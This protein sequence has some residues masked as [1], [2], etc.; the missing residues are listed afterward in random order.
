MTGMK[1]L[2]WSVAEEVCDHSPIGV[3]SGGWGS[4]HNRCDEW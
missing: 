3:K 2:G 4:P 1:K